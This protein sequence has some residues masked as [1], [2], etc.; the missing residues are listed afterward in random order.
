MVKGGTC[1]EAGEQ[2][3]KKPLAEKSAAFHLSS[4]LR[5]GSI[6]GDFIYTI[7]KPTQWRKRVSWE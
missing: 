6:C 4:L 1:S 3:F 7:N 5:A 2:R